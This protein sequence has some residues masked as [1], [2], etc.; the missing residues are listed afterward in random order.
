MLY[1]KVFFGKMADVTLNTLVTIYVVKN[2]R[3]LASIIGFFNMFLWII[4]V[5][6]TLTHAKDN[7]FVAV[8]YSLGYA[9]GTFCGTFISNIFN[10]ENI[11]IQIITKD[12]NKC[13]SNLIKD[14]NYPAL[15]VKCNEID[16]NNDKFIIYTKINNKDFKNFKNLIK[17]QDKHVSIIC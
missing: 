13:I 12:E 11:N 16:D 14:K 2:K 3:L 10:N 1:A 17:G 6:E 4:V 5:N 9:A 15:I 7:I 8:I